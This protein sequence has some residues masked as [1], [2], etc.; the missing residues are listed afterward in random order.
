MKF[1][2]PNI[3]GEGMYFSYSML[4]ILLCVISLCLT[5]YFLTKQKTK[6]EKAATI[7]VLIAQIGLYG[8]EDFFT[9][10]ICFSIAGYLSLFWIRG[11]E[12]E[13]S[14]IAIRWLCWLVLPGMIMTFGM[15]LLSHYAGTFHY[16]M[17]DGLWKEQK[18]WM[19]VAATCYLIGYGSR[20]GLI[21]FR[22]WMSS[23][24]RYIPKENAWLIKILLIPGG[25][26]QIW[27][28]YPIFYRE[29]GFQ[30]LLFFFIAATI[31]WSM[32]NRWLHRRNVE[33][34]EEVTKWCS[35]EALIYEPVFCTALP[36]LFGVVFRILDYLPDA[37]VAFLR[38]SV[39]RDSKQK[40][41]DKVGTPFTY[42]LG[43][44]FDEIIL[45]LNKTIYRQHPI[46]KS[47]V[48]GFAVARKEWEGTRG[49]ITKSVSFGL[50]LFCIGMCIT[51]FYLFI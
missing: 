35:V 48:N 5:L 38:G 29:A 14:N 45:L 18:M 49:I 50:L 23:V 16:E 36:F 22:G 13:A 12:K 25:L 7:G 24:L 33:Y 4:G 2:I 46:Q 43:T 30:K 27:K 44:V 3:C 8:A 6:L 32:L 15:F 17:L 21:G 42:V 20:C 26:W 47:F 31:I 34:Y 40:V 1:I 9:S 11:E 19:A 41:W 51:L 28:A 37:I 39:Y 10:Y